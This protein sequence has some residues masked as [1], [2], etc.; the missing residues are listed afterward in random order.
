MRILG[1]IHTF[2]DNDVLDRSLKALLGQ[3]RPLDAI[4]LVDNGST[5]GTLERP[6][7]SNVTIIRHPENRGTSG[8]LITGFRYALENGYDWIWVFD[9][10]SMPRQD[11][12]AALLGFYEKLPAQ[13]QGKIQL[14]A[15]TPSDASRTPQHGVMF[16]PDGY[17]ELRYADGQEAYECH[18]VIWSGSLF[19]V[20]TIRAIGL[21]S[22]D[23]VLDWGEFEYGYQG[24]VR[25]Y[26]TYVVRS[27][28]FDHNIGVR[29]PSH[30]TTVQIGP[31]MLSVTSLPPIRLYYLIRNGIFFWG[32]QYPKR[33]IGSYLGVARRFGW[34][35]KYIVK[36][37]L[38]SRWTE[39]RACLRG[40]RDGMLGRMRRRY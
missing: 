32:Y 15:A 37:A 14:L 22:P 9:A 4:L 19:R 33:G 5:D 23:Y 10:D 2:N 38:L 21:P 30:L 28:I 29:S 18:A 13:M 12:L 20:E 11:A 16:T 26:K 34:I 8:A 25:G 40:V 39:L 36:L 3:T 24:M 17:E 6:F 1:H 31:L 7:P 35:P 27:S